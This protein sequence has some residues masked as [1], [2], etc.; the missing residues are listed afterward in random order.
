M[1][2]AEAVRLS[3]T[4]G[5]SSG[6]VPATG[7]IWVTEVAPSSVTSGKVRCTLLLR[8]STVTP[9]P[10]K[11]LFSAVVIV[12]V[13]FASVVSTFGTCAVSVARISTLCDV[14]VSSVYVYGDSQPSHGP[15]S[16][17]HSKVIS[18]ASV[19]LSVAENSRVA[20]VLAVRLGGPVLM[21]VFGASTSGGSWI[22]HAYDTASPSRR[23]STRVGLV[24]NSSLTA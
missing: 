23:R 16:S 17:E 12:H 20:V 14:T 6:S 5:S 15:P 18:S 19:R 13:C 4:S 11:V 22:D 7:P 9:V 8:R 1:I 21:V 10:T 2:E 3:L 24:T